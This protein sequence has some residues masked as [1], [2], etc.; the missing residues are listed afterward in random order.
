MITPDHF[1]ERI[2]AFLASG[3]MTATDLGIKAVRDPN[4]VGDVLKRG[5]VP[6]L[7]LASKVLAVIDQEN[8]IRRDE[9]RAA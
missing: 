2:R 8:A 5:R 6:S 4:F 3:A 1:R 9:G 7:T